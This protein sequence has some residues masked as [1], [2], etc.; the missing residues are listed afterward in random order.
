MIL[1][2]LA[3]TLRFVT[4]KND[5]C[6]FAQ[7]CQVCFVDATSWMKDAQLIFSGGESNM[8]RTDHTL[9]VNSPY[10]GC[11]DSISPEKVLI[12]GPSVSPYG[13]SVSIYNPC[14]IVTLFIVYC[15]LY[16]VYCVL[17]TAYIVLCTLLTGSELFL[18][19]SRVHT[20]L[21]GMVNT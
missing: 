2:V 6:N 7:K 21:T 16:I 5:F 4:R 18:L 14:A 10:M 17:C 20:L 1:I 11:T 3:E 12:Y 8:G 15:A 19:F 13:P 9:M